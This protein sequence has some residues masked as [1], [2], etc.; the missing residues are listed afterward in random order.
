MTPAMKRA[1]RLIPST[2][3][4]SWLLVL[5]ERRTVE[6]TTLVE[7]LCAACPILTTCRELVLSF[8]DILRRRAKDELDNWLETAKGSSL[9]L[10]ASFV[11]GIRADYAA[12]KAAFTLEWSNGPTEGHVNRLK[13]I[14]RQGYGQ[15]G[16]DLLK[17]RV[18]PPELVVG[19]L[20]AVLFRK[21]SDLPY[22]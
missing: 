5:P 18:L 7:E 10:F 9:A 15:A 21:G 14:K 4:L 6:Q 2:R 22:G 13:F 16:F 8:Q 12:V 1:E 19:Q 11:R 3:A 20:R 17:R